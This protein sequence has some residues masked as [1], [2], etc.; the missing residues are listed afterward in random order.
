MSAPLKNS[1]CTLEKERW[2]ELLRLGEKDAM[3]C[4]SREEVNIAN[5]ILNGRNNRRTESERE[6]REFGFG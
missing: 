3:Q 2:F 6:E 5:H 4:L 1:G